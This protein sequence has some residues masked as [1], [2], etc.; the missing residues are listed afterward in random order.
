MLAR[1]VGEQRIEGIDE[2]ADRDMAPRIRR[3]DAADDD[4]SGMHD[5]AA[6]GV[7]AELALQACFQGGRIRGEA[8]AGGERA[9]GTRGR[10]DA[11]LMQRPEL[12]TPS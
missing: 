12:L 10:A 11:F 1:R 8:L 2:L 6:G 3:A 9:A 5:D 7:H 4:G